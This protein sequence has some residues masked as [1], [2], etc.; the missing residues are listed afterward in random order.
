MSLTVGE[1]FSMYGSG[2]ILQ[3]KGPWA[4]KRNF[5]KKVARNGVKICLNGS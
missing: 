3:A 2:D 1:H 5:M 4:W